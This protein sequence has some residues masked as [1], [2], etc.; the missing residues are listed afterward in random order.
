MKPSYLAVALLAAL[1]PGCP[2]DDGNPAVL[3]L[4]LDGTETQVKLVDEEPRPY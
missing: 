3:W 2:S 4:A 1:L